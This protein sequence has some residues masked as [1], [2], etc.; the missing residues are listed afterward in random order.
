MKPEPTPPPEQRTAVYCNC[1]EIALM[2]IGNDNC[3]PRCY[4]Q[5]HKPPEPKRSENA[6]CRDI[7]QAYAKSLKAPAGQIGDFAEPVR[8]PG[9]DREEVF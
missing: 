3:C 7:R 5:H 9:E 1:G 4:A 2:R 8:E 6:V